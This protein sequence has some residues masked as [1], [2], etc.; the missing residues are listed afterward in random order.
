M[1]EDRNNLLD[2]FIA[3]IK[4]AAY[5]AEDWFFYQTPHAQTTIAG[6]AVIL[7]IGLVVYVLF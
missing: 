7:S 6:A 5:A 4:K 3:G 2:G 1:I